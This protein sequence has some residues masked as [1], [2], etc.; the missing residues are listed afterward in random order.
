M[1]LTRPFDEELHS[2][3]TESLA[4]ATRLALASSPGLPIEHALQALAERLRA[5]YL[6]PPFISNFCQPPLQ[7]IWSESILDA[8]NGDLLRSG[9]NRWLLVTYSQGPRTPA[10]VAATHGIG[11][12]A[13]TPPDR[14]MQ[15]SGGKARHALS[16]KVKKYVIAEDQLGRSRSARQSAGQLTPAALAYAKA[17]GFH[18]SEPNAE[19]TVYRWI[20]EARK[21]P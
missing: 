15:R 20:L 5:R 4:M 21:Q 13:P 14:S 11:P 16:E 8:I 9:Y 12:G 1:T 10:Q 3:G 6:S 7:H 17:V 18:M 2:L 19:N